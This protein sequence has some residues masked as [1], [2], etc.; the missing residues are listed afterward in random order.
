MRLLAAGLVLWGLVTSISSQTIYPGELGYWDVNIT[1][2]TDASGFESEEITA[3]HSMTADKIIS[4]SWSHNPRTGDFS[5]ARNDRAFEAN[6]NGGCGVGFSGKLRFGSDATEKTEADPSL[7]SHHTQAS[8]RV[9]AQWQV[10]RIL[11][12]WHC[13]FH[14]QGQ[15]CDGSWRYRLRS[16]KCDFG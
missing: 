8:N 7:V 14:S 5:T 6:I 12:G 16:C 11:V 13:K 15:S 3:V 9:A 1:Y 10:A 2:Y 4:S